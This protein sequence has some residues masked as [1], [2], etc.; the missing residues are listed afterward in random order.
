MLVV[1]GLLYWFWVSTGL[2]SF[3][4]SG[5]RLLKVL[6]QVNPRSLL[7]LQ[8]W[9]VG[10]ELFLFH[11]WRCVLL[12]LLFRSR[13]L[14]RGR[15]ACSA[16]SHGLAALDIR[17]LP[18][19]LK[20]CRL[21]VSLTAACL[22]LWAYIVS[23]TLFYSLP[24]G[25]LHLFQFFEVAYTWIIMFHRLLYGRPLR[26]ILVYRQHDLSQRQ[27]LLCIIPLFLLTPR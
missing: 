12:P 24:P 23:R 15:G 13:C 17:F 14:V 20:V 5:D 10:V 22:N 7:Q 6:W 27:Y 9:A 18:L 3:R 19:H 25:L 26:W 1:S 2:G 8:F 11:Y 16:A 21:Q 4:H